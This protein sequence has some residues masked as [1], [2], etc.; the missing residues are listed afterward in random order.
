MKRANT[1]D[2]YIAS[3]PKELQ[4][5]LKEIRKIIR[6]AAP[7]ASEKISYGMPYYGYKGRL[8]YFA[9]F[10][11][12]LGLYGMPEVFDQ[13]NDD[14]TKFRTGKATLRLEFDKKLPTALI[15]KLI[16]TGVKRNESKK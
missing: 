14:L 6:T 4:G 3:A 13:Y 15:R 12:H 10:K 16:K 1:V 8:V 5:K 9:Y 2:E 11:D 7:G